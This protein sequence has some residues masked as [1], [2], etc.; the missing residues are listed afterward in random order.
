MWDTSSSSCSESE[1]GGE[2]ETSPLRLSKK[3]QEIPSLAKV[4]KI[5]PI[6][7]VGEA[8]KISNVQISVGGFIVGGFPGQSRARELSAKRKPDE[9][10]RDA[11]VGR[12]S[13][14]K[15]SAR[16]GRKDVKKVV[17]RKQCVK[18]NKVSVLSFLRVIRRGL[19]FLGRGHRGH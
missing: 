18:Y 10:K 11:K 7:E 5:L 1:D 9:E 19:P 13:L 12:K 8:A 2:E 6:E 16:V 4:K 15:K 17:T 14:V 3:L